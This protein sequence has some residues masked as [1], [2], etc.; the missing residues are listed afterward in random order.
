[1]TI[2]PVKA[3]RPRRRTSVDSEDRFQFLVTV[4]FGVVVALVALIL[5]GSVGLNFYN[6]HLKPVATVAGTGITQDEWADR[7]RLGSYRIS[8]AEAAVRQALAAGQIDEATAT[9]RLQS[10]STAAANVDSQAIS[11]LIDLA[12]QA[13]LAADRGI[14]V[15]DVDI[16]EAIQREA[17]TPERRQIEAI[18]VQPDAAGDAPTPEEHAAALAK[19]NE[20][21]AALQSGTP[22]AQAAQQYST[23]VSK[24]SGGEYGLITSENT[25]DDAWVAALFELPLN[26]TTGIIKGE[27]GIYRIGR[28]TSIV[29]GSTDPQFLTELQKSVSLDAYRAN[30][31]REKAAVDLRDSVTEEAISGE[32]DQAHLAEIVIKGSIATSEATSEG[33]IRAS[34]ILYSPKDDPAGAQDLLPDDPAWAAAQAEAQTAA[35]QMRAIADP[36]ARAAAFADLART[37]SDD[38]DSGANGGD[39]DWFSRDLM[40]PEFANPLFDHPELVTGD[41]VGPVTSDFGWHVILF[42]G[43]R[44]STE[45]RLQQVLDRLDAPGADFAAIARE[46]SDG[47]EAADG[48]DLGWLVWKQLP[49]GSQ[50]DVFALTPGRV[51]RGI[52]LED[53]YHIY[54]MLERG[55][56]ALDPDQLPL[57]RDSAFSDWYADLKTTAEDDGTI[58]RDPGIFTP[59]DE[60]NADTVS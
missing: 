49:S 2:R 54:R 59:S 18:F 57:V 14:V 53:G 9:T 56:R 50:D 26:G 48:G 16:D 37:A 12:F 15:T 39:L 44:A 35:D 55:D 33:E 52:A 3:E 25:T 21:L 47:D 22:F 40:L 24:E 4:G 11:D 13:K 20:A 42:V 34:H 27:D 38:T 30:I 10:L 41:I 29:P 28:V 5:V 17:S 1:M 60:I 23:D 8:R 31:R 36:T 51:T 32:V 45:D 7:S 58:T 46:S 6:S 43:R 19:A